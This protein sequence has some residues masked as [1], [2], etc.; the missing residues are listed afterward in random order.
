M[1]RDSPLTSLSP[2]PTPAAVRIDRILLCAALLFIWPTLAHAQVGSTTDILTGVVTGPDSRPLQGA[3][4]DATAA[5]GQITRHALTGS[6]GRYTILFPDGGGQYRVTVRFLGMAPATFLMSRQADEDRL[7]RD[8]ALSPTSVRLQEVT[9]NA[10]RRTP[11]EGNTPGATGR[12]LSGDQAE[13]LPV[14]ASDL[15]GLAALAPG[16]VPI[17]ATDSTGSAFSVAGQRPTSNNITLDG[18]SFGGASIPQD[19]TRSTRIITNTYD[20]ARGQFSGGQ[21]ATTT[22]GGS[23]TPA[24]SFSYALRD[25]ALEWGESSNGSFGGGSTQNQLGGGFG[26]P[27]IHDKLFF[28]AAAQGR[29][30]SDDLASLLSANPATLGRLGV[31]ADSVTRFLALVN[32]QGV[33]ALEESV[34]DDR[35]TNAGSALARMD[36]I[37]NDAHSL[38]IRGDWRLNSQDPTRVSAYSL[39]AGGGTMRDQGGG[40]MA[41]LSSH[42]GSTIINEAR[43]YASI[44]DRHSSPFLELPAARVQISSS[45]ALGIT[46]LGFGGSSSLP[47]TANTKTLEVSDEL[48]WLPGDASHRIKLG[49]LLNASSFDQDVTNNRDG[50]FTFNSLQDLENDQPSSFS[51]TLAPSTRAGSAVNPALYLGDTWRKSSA[52]QLNYGVRLEGSVYGG[53]PTENPLV[54]SAFGLRTNDFPSEVHLSPRV[55]FTWT[56]GQGGFGAP[57]TIIRG[58]AGEFRSLTPSALFSAAEGATGVEGSESQLVCIG[59]AVPTPDWSAYASNP[60]AIPTTCASATPL[61]TSTAVPNVAAFNPNFGAPRAWRASL[62]VQ[63]RILDRFGVSL[64]ASYARGVSLYGFQDVNLVTQP[65]F[66]LASENDRPVYVPASSIVPGTGA[67]DFTQSRAVSSLGHV[68]EIGSNLQSDNKQLTL[69]VNGVT[70]SGFTF[71]ASYTFMRSRD[72]SSFSCCSAAQGFAAATTAGNPN[73]LGWATSDFERRHSFLVTASYALS[74]SVELTTVTRLVSGTPYTPTV[75]G[76][77]NGDG[78]ANDRAFIFTGSARDS[79]VA[80]GMSRLLAASS[81][82]VRSCLTSRMGSIA[83]RNSCTGSWQP[84]ADLQL[85]FRPSWWGLDRRMSIMVSTVNM[86]AGLDQLLHGNDNLRGWGGFTRP[87]PTLLFV[88]GFDPVSQ[89]FTYEV[90][91]RFGSTRGSAN[92]FRVPFQLAVQARYVIGPDQNA[93][94]MRGLPGGGGRGGGGQNGAG[95]GEGAEANSDDLADRLQ[96]MLPNPAA[97]ILEI[98]DSL[99]LTDSQVVALTLLRDSTAAKYAVI[100]DSIRVGLT[101]VGANAD[102][103]RMF[104]VM[105][106]QLTKGRALSRDVLQRAQAILTPEQWAKVPERIRAPGAGRRGFG[107]NGP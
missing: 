80:N 26:G 15:A 73:A 27:L 51:R 92:A 53:A 24:G 97:Q 39:P 57:A 31:A 44:D 67:L 41:A 87:D 38:M 11:R 52:L 68:I 49:G 16:V 104:A 12:N 34:G 55:G 8:V 74:Q 102:P 28:F 83:N 65:R 33:P 48:S 32:A 2:P 59:S 29:W 99:A 86:L 54:E 72:Q 37:I 81:S 71:Q 64:D 77:I 45:G 70:V 100:A 103:A 9:V 56:V 91:Q 20:V 85:N 21:V 35:S 47:Q 36:Y 18:L 88:R 5:E 58:G 6:N 4:V 42:F 43:A 93:E 94:R 106:P 13:R 23:N 95:P 14:D 60:S 89:S 107:G 22:R 69:G 76:D 98:R 82:S 7:V 46:T 19:A 101:K 105:R 40:L 90:N 66:G 75:S 30:R 78:A 61:A 63:R 25:R 79:A 10:R 3:T 17:G 62:G 50:V 96:R 84:T 1:T